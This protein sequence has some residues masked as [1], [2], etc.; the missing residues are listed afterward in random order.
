MKLLKLTYSNNIFRYILR[1]FEEKKR[2]FCLKNKIDFEYVNC[3]LS[4]KYGWYK[5]FLYDKFLKGNYDAIWISDYDST[6]INESYEIKKSIDLNLD[7]LVSKLP[8][9]NF[10][11]F[12]SAILT[13]NKKVRDVI[14]DTCKKFTRL[15]KSK[16]F[17]AEEEI[18]NSYGLD[19]K[20][21]NNIN[22]IYGIHNISNPF[23]IHFAGKSN[24]YNIKNAYSEYNT[25]KS[26]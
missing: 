2:E 16:N 6:I 9:S 1:T 21:D 23:L 24:P 5:I 25:T 8:N 20:I 18:L 7:G 3:D 19:L 17:L 4:Y 14:S 15:E 10:N 22:C 26:K 12:G 13:N 11:L